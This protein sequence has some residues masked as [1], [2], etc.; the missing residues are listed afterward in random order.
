M[1]NFTIKTKLMLLYICCVFLPLVLTDGVILGLLVDNDRRVQSY[2]MEQLANAIQYD[3]TYAIDNAVNLTSNVYMNT[4][5]ENFLNTEYESN[6]DYYLALRDFEKTYFFGGGWSYGVNSVVIYADNDT[7]VNGGHFYRLSAAA[8][9]EWLQEMSSQDKDMLLR[10]YYVEESVQHTYPKRRISIIRRLDYFGIDEG[11]EKVLRLDLDYGTLVRAL[12]N[13][14]KAYTAYICS[15]DSILFSNQGNAADTMDFEHLTGEEEIGYE[16]NI[17]YYGQELRLLVLRKPSSVGELIRKHAPLFALLIAM[18]MILPMILVL[19]LNRSFTKRLKVLSEAFEESEVDNLQEITMPIGEDEI[20]NLMRGYN[21]MVQRSKELIKTAYTDRLKRQEIDLA[22]QNAE[23]MALHSQIDPHF[24]FNVLESIRMHS[25]LKH[26]META[27]MIEQLAILERQNVSWKK[28]VITIKEEITF[29]RAYLELQRYRF[30]E[31]L[32]YEI[33]ISP[34]CEAYKIPKLTL[35]TFVENACVHGVE[36][37]SSTTW[38]YV[39]VYQKAETLYLEVEDT[40]CGM[41][42]DVITYM[43]DKM[44]NCGIEDLKK[45]DHVGII[46]ACLR[47]KLVTQGKAQFELESEEGVGTFMVIRIPLECF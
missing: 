10:I 40:G 41:A 25:I 21:R 11:C 27:Q 38:I 9:E 24:L 12:S 15:G 45:E 2:E 37:K 30:G 33:T 19:V 26:E 28:D 29:I 23:L 5:I 6:L 18:N 16:R 42:E 8:K 1:N 31:R 4:N 20:G 13:S 3:F 14:P 44:N 36:Q 39:R 46:N 22:R 7:I 17:S 43:A 34:D 32:H 47:L 35:V